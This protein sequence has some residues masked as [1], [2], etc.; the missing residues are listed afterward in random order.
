M[1]SHVLRPYATCAGITAALLILAVAAYMMMTVSPSQATHL[2][3]VSHQVS[4]SQYGPTYITQ[5]C[6]AMPQF[7][8]FASAPWPLG[9]PNCTDDLEKNKAM[10]YTTTLNIPQDDLNFSTVV[11]MTP[12]TTGITNNSPGTL[13]GG[14]ASVTHLGVGNGACDQV[15]DIDFV[16]YSIALPDNLGDPR[17]STNIVFP[18]AIG[19]DFRFDSWNVGSND[20][21]TTIT[22][23]GGTNADSSNVFIQNYP[24]YLLDLFD[25]DFV[26]GGSDGTDKPLVPE[27]VY[28]GA[29][30]I[31][32]HY[33]PLFFASFAPGGLE[34]L[35]LPLG[36]TDGINAAMGRPSV[37][38]LNDPVAVEASKSLVTDFCS[39]LNTITTI[40]PNTHTSPD[41]GTQYAVAY[42]ASQRDLEQDTYENSL[43]SCPKDVNLG[44][45][46]DN[47]DLG[48]DADQDRIDDVCDGD[49]TTTFNVNVDD[50]GFDNAQDTCPQTGDPDPTPIAGPPILDTNAD[51]EL[52]AG[53]AADRG[54]RGD[55]IGT[56]CDSGTVNILCTGG[57]PYASLGTSV[58]Q[59]GH[60]VDITLSDSVGNG[61]YHVATNVSVFCFGDDASGGTDNDNDGYC[62][63]DDNANSGESNIFVHN[64]WGPSH[65]GS[66]MDTDKDG[67]SDAMETYLG[68][69]GTK[70]CA[71][72]DTIN[73]E[74]PLDNFPLDFNDDNVLNLGDVLKYNLP[75]GDKIDVVTDAPAEYSTD[76]LWGK[77][78]DLNNDG[79]LNLGD[80]LK[81]NLPFGKKCGVSDPLDVIPPWSQQ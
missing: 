50:D 47:L 12:E 31:A 30:L 40:L 5:Y 34:D 20:T 32:G 77:R 74:S 45:P 33:V 28:G 7:G 38:V 78:L 55:A 42:S 65:P 73:D 25:P 15:L 80:V 4:G 13:V 44:N 62:A 17:A 36:S 11:T 67:F 18:R 61:R 1:T 39:E 58:C 52:T 16:L 23:T 56:L 41:A 22:V 3:P 21:G 24:S 57:P 37:A 66:Q 75:F 68:T 81:Y 51:D 53:P 46:R 49:N 27:A 48:A 26:P 59:N 71:Q 19:A 70:S 63:A 43:D 14:L 8:A 9:D 10:A 35:P 76:L 69:D 2:N 72:S 64:V 6:N 60:L 29:T 54:P 79:I